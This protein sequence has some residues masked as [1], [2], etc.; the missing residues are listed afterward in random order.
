MNHTLPS[1]GASR[2]V[3][4]LQGP[5]SP[6]W[7]ELARAFAARGVRV[8][9][10][11]FCSADVMFWRQSGAINYRGRP[12]KWPAFLADLIQRESVSDILYFSDRFPYHV[13]AQDIARSLTVKT[14]AVEFG[15]LRP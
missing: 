9:K 8:L 13:A 5:P 15:Y 14:H 6:F 7:N 1:A 12:G 4:F 11:N 10:V 2:T 3:L